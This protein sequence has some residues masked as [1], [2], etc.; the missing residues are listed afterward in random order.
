[1]SEPFTGLNFR[2]EIM[3]PGAAEP[4]CEAAFA[5]CDGM[6]MRFDVIRFREGGD[7]TTHLA[8]GP[9][10][11]GE[12]TLRRGMTTSFDLWDWCGAALQGQPQRADVRVVMLSEDGEERAVFRLW[13]CLPVRLKAPRLDA[14]HA[15]VAIE[16]LQIACEALT[17]E[18]SE[19]KRPPLQK[20]ELRELDEK[21]QKE[22]NKERWV[23][24]QLNPPELRVAHAEG[25]ARLDLD[26]WLEGESVRESTARVAHF[27]PPGPPV[28]FAWGK[29]RFDGRVEAME[30]TLDG[31]APDGRPLRAR[32]ALVLRGSVTA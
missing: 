5:E 17:L 11:F 32:L 6:E 27:A 23:V 9:A 21:L 24:L 12:V 8:P 26:V 16:E 2:V 14:M 19:P 22:V 28:R 3:L 18:G 29:F 1:M 13:R 31:F 7:S 20:A 10:S 25:G 4:L 30:E 15:A